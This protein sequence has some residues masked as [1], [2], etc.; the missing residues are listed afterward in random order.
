VLFFS[1]AAIFAYMLFF[2]DRGERAVVQGMMIGAVVAVIVT[3]L[4][5]IRFLDNPFSS[6]YGSLQPV[7]MERTLRILEQGR[8]VVGQSG[9][10]PCDEEGKLV[11]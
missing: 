5:L 1:A 2:A 3:T 9:P 11:G 10:L 6:G 8:E 4:G 7:A